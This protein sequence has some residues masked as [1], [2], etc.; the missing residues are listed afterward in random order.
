M[1]S[2]T[3]PTSQA[4]HLGSLWKRLEGLGLPVVLLVFVLATALALPPL[5]Q[6]NEFARTVPFRVLSDPTPSWS[7]QVAS[8]R[9]MQMSEV[10][11]FESN[12]VA[13]DVWVQVD[14]DETQGA[15]WLMF[16]SKNIRAVQCWS[17]PTATAL[18]DGTR[19]RTLGPIQPVGPGYAVAVDAF[20]SAGTDRL[21]CRL[22]Q[23]VASQLVVVP[24]ELSEVLQVN[25]SFQRESSL[26]EGAAL[27]LSVS[28]LVAAGITRKPVFLIGSGLGVP[29]LCDP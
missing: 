16:P 28:L 6:L 13:G 5:K 10:D 18:A 23:N 12:G 20:R 25:A 15:A 7:A 14:L 19:H 4:G 2:R 3:P 9:L 8:E 29:W 24:I 11:S 1:T 17:Q 27:M 21:L 26:L 22:S